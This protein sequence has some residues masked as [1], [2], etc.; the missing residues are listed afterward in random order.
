MKD[1]DG[2]KWISV[3]H[4]IQNTLLMDVAPPIT[5]RGMEIFTIATTLEKHNVSHSADRECA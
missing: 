5:F 2:M 3:E 1:F 4:D